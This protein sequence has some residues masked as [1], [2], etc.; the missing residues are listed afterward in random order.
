M[1]L[2]EFFNWYTLVVFFLCLLVIW[3]YFSLTRAKGVFVLLLAFVWTMVVRAGIS[4]RVDWI[5]DH[6]RPLTSITATL[7]LIGLLLLLHSLRKFYRSGQAA[8]KDMADERESIV[9]KREF[10][11]DSRERVADLRDDAADE[12]EAHEQGK[13]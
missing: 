7:Y 6:A 12:R 11:A 2:S 13:E 1:A 9:D 3:R 4:F 10:N 5:D 8:Q